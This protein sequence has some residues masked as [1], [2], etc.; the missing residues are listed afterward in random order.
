MKINRKK[1]D[2]SFQR[3]QTWLFVGFLLIILMDLT[4]QNCIVNNSIS[5]SKIIDKLDPINPGNSA[6]Y[7]KFY[8]NWKY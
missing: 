3:I 7:F 2:N 1:L 4:V 6:T 8:R 5:K